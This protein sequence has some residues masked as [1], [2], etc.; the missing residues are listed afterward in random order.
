MEAGV[1][2]FVRGAEAV[3]SPVPPSILLDRTFGGSFPILDAT[4]PSPFRRRRDRSKLRIVNFIALSGSAGIWGPA[5]INASLLA[6]SEINRRGGILGREI[7]LVVRD[8]GGDI[9][10]VVQQ[11]PI[12]STTMME[13]SSS[14]RTSAPCVSLCARWWPGG[15]PIST[16]RSMRA[17][18]ARRA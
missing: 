1:S 6:V 13:I 12:S 7:E 5:S 2:A 3:G 9:S 15:C 8:A 10:D 16:P 17:A 18:S 4:D 11:A 14:A